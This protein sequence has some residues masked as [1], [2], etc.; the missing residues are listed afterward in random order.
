MFKKVT[1]QVIK[2]HDA[3]ITS[4]SSTNLVLVLCI[5][6]A[7]LAILGMALLS[8]NPL[9]ELTI[10]AQTAVSAP[11]T[12]EYHNEVRA[13]YTCAFGKTLTATYATGEV[14][15]QLSDGRENTLYDA[16]AISGARYVS[17]DG[18]VVFWTA[19]N[20][21]LLEEGGRVTYTGCIVTL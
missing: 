17:R 3:V 11:V 18:E 19:D 15:I 9:G 6:I 5:G 1:Q 14:H 8:L 20:T 13:A 7:G 4:K 2:T 12:E 16:V 21:A 10:E